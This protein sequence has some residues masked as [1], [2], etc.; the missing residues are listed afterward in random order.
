MTDTVRLRKIMSDI[1]NCFLKRRKG[2]IQEPKNYTDV[3]VALSTMTADL[4]S[5]N[6]IKK[7]DRGYFWANFQF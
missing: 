3:S 2:G 6:K 4:F 5:L 7:R 1:L